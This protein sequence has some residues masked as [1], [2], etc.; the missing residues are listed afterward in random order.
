MMLKLKFH[1]NLSIFNYSSR[2]D[3]ELYFNE[4]FDELRRR[5]FYILGFLCF[6]TSIAFYNVKLIVK[7]LED[8]VSKIHFFSYHLENILFQL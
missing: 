7:I 3:S 8:P 1:S 5:L 6:F 2:S 4:H